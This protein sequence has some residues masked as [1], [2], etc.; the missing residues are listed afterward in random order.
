[1]S[2]R[3]LKKTPPIPVI[4]AIIDSIFFGRGLTSRPAEFGYNNRVAVN[5]SPD[6]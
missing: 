3:L 4:L 2:S 6:E 1:L 5:A